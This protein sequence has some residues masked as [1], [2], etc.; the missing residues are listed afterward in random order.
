VTAGPC[1]VKLRVGPSAKD[2]FRFLDS[3]VVAAIVVRCPGS[4][5]GT[6]CDALTLPPPLVYARTYNGCLSRCSHQTAPVTTG[7]V[8]ELTKRFLR[9]WR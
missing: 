8:L 5:A 6:E 2:C 4:S 9:P 1:P 3:R 7:L